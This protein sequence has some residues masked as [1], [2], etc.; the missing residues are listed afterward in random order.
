MDGLSLPAAVA[1][2]PPVVVR[3][4]LSDIVGHVVGVVGMASLMVTVLA[5]GHA[6]LAGIGAMFACF[7]WAAAAAVRLR[8]RPL[9]DPQIGANARASIVD[10]F[11]MALLMAAPYVMIGTG[12]HT[13]HGGGGGSTWSMAPTATLIL[14]ALIVGG[15]VRLRAGVA[16]GVLVERIDFW[17]GAVM[18]TGMLVAM[19]VPHGA[20]P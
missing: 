9:A 14:S 3:E 6:S 2:P 17:A 8:A 20:T 5:F 10:P 13:H 16:R 15:W 1:A 11:A 18:M 12:G 4:R 7:F 19:S